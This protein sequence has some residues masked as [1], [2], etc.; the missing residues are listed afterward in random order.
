MHQSLTETLP[1]GNVG[2]DKPNVLLMAST[3]VASINVDGTTI[4][5]ALNIPVE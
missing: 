3:G 1:Y 5:I 4:H 2:A